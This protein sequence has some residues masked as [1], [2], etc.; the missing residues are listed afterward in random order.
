MR[1][2]VLVLAFVSFVLLA[3]NVRAADVCDVEYLPQ[4]VS[5]NSSALFIV[6]ETT[7]QSKMHNLSQPMKVTYWIADSDFNVVDEGSLLKFGDC[8]VC[9]FSGKFGDFY[10]SCGPT[11][12]RDSGQYKM[13]FTGK[14]FYSEKEFNRTILIHGEQL[15]AGVNVFR[16]I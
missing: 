4:Y 3:G 12:F 16:S 7:V 15:S 2:V 8:W 5:A 1:K 11:P 9:E 13:Y 10:G 6:P 14:D